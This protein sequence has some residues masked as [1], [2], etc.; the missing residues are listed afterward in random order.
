MDVDN[1]RIIIA[2]DHTTVVVCGH[3]GTGGRH[4]VS[5]AVVEVACRPSVEERARVE[6]E[7]RRAQAER[8]WARTHPYLYAEDG[9]EA[10]AASEERTSWITGL[11]IVGSLLAAVI[12]A[13]ASIALPDG[14]LAN[15]FVIVIVA[16]VVGA[17]LI[18]PA[19]MVAALLAGIVSGIADWRAER[20]AR[21]RAEPR[22][23]AERLARET[24]E[25]DR[26]LSELGIDL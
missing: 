24:A 10:H 19:T 2:G 7:R 15:A 17:V 11:G 5:P 4:S 9:A 6:R 13:L 23:R 21:Q 26:R 1:G 8:A 25:N 18:V 20:A 14:L 22:E 16:A 12:W 3:C